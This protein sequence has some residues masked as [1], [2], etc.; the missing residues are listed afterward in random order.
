MER[1]V[2]GGSI[3]FAHCSMNFESISLGKH[4]KFLCQ[5]N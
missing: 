2:R 3:N 4:T 1:F 5:F